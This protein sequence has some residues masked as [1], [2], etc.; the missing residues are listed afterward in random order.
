MTIVADIG[1]RAVPLVKVI[2]VI[3]YVIAKPLSMILDK[4]LG[5]EAGKVYSKEEVRPADIL[6]RTKIVNSW[7]FPFS[8]ISS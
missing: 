2:I 1:S 3:L 4:V 7:H 6:S 8:S 5:E